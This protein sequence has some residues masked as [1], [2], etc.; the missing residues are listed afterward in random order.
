MRLYKEK[1]LSALLAFAMCAV[2]AFLAVRQPWDAGEE[3]RSIFGNRYSESLILWYADEAL[4]DYLTSQALAYQEQYHV[5]IE[6]V[7]VPGLEYLEQISKV[8]VEGGEAPDL[9]LTNNG[10]LEKAY[11]AGLARQVEDGS[12]LTTEHFP[13]AALDAVSW[14][15]KNVAYPLY[16]EAAF[17]LYNKTYMEDH[18]RERIQAEAD[19]AEGEAAQAAADANAGEIGDEDEGMPD[20]IEA[21]SSDDV[22]EEEVMRR[23]EEAVPS[24][25]DDILTFAD[26]YNA[27]ENVEAVFKW[28][29][30]D[31]FYNYFM[32]GN[33]ISVGGDAGDTPEQMDVFNEETIAC[34]D[35]Y[36]ALNQFFS[37][38]S[39]EVSY[40]GIIDEFLE[41]RTVFTIAT[42]DVF[43]KLKLAKADGT[44]PY[45]YGVAALPDVS[46]QLKS[47]GCSVTNCVAVNGY[48]EKGQT[49][50]R[51]AAWL[52]TEGADKLYGLSGK[53]ASSYDVEYEE[54]QI[55]DA[56]LEYE[57][58][59]PVPKLMS[60]QNFWVEL[61]IVFTKVWNG[62]DVEETLQK[63]D[64]TLLGN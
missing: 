1:G 39:K 29:V 31:I 5:R 42:T 61:E 18:A 4:S 64:D 44:F 2:L 14:H 35:V 24:S 21:D 12:L 23:M 17:L 27:P 49:A 47:R 15:G 46:A 16:Y 22:S 63:L 3:N 13:K 8:S 60:A 57:K 45:E 40:A 48:S 33:Y 6:P 28:D 20:L 10:N 9:Y 30:S 34:L 25:I 54:E 43:E 52:V 37:I 11:L 7:L 56:M 58:S 26:E 36:Q 50:D 59:V 41:G 38:D 53:T 51:F 62:A 32:V 19:A 55:A